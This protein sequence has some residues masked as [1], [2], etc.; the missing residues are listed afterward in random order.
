MQENAEALE[1]DPFRKSIE[2]VA[3][4]EM[5]VENIQR[6]ALFLEMQQSAAIFFDL[7]KKGVK[8]KDLSL[9]KQKLDE[10]TLLYSDDA[11]YTALLKSELPQ[12]S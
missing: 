6:S 12:L 9:A 11:A 8:G 10:L 5:G 7:V 3:E 4:E 2:E 1:T